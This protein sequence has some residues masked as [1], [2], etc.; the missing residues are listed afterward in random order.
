MIVKTDDEL[1]NF[2]KSIKTNVDGFML[3]EFIEADIISC[4]VIGST[5]LT[6]LSVHVSVCLSFYW[7]VLGPRPPHRSKLYAIYGLVLYRTYNTNASVCRFIQNEKLSHH[8][9]TTTTLP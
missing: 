5:F 9:A 7:L 2:V 4:V 6:H 3:R 8:L 1:N